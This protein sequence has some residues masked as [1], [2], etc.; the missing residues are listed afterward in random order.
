M[1][2]IAF[3]FI[4]GCSE[5]HELSMTVYDCCGNVN[6]VSVDKRKTNHENEII[7]MDFVNI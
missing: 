2:R 4:F 3:K 7:T 1:S 6:S 5:S